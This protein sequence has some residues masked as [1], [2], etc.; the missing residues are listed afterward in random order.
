L[1]NPN[2]FIR[3]SASDNQSDHVK[4]ITV[5][6]PPCDY[7]VTDAGEGFLPQWISNGAID[8]KPE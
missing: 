5:H 1:L 7:L 8:S 4:R 3:F 2:P 6:R